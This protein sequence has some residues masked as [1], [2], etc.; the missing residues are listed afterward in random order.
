M[1][2]PH[3]VRQVLER[4]VKDA[5]AAC[6][7]AMSLARVARETA[8]RTQGEAAASALEIQV[9]AFGFAEQNVASAFDFAQRLARAR[10]LAEYLELQAEYARAQIDAFGRQAEDLHQMLSEAAVRTAKTAQDGS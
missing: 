8:G 7:Q 4:N 6:D 3:G 9:A 5:R 10:D 2:I 1:T